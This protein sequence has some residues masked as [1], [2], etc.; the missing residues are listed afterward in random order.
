MEEYEKAE[1][2][3][4]KAAL[5]KEMERVRA[6]AK[7]DAKRKYTPKKVKVEQLKNKAKPLKK[8]LKRYGDNMRKANKEILG[9]DF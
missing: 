3:E 9:F 2:L 6:K 7:A 1:A 8:K 5:T 4:Q